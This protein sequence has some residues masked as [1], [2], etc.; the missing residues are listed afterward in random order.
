MD[1]RVVKFFSEN[2][3]CTVA[4]CQNGNPRASALEYVKVDDGII[5]ATDP[6]SIKAENLKAN[7]KLSISVHNMPV[8]V[9]VD[10]TTT[11]PSEAEINTYN[12]VLFERHPEFVEMMEKGMMRPFVYYKV[13]PETVYYNDYSK[14]MSPTEIISCK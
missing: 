13:V 7:N 9:T 6:S 10:G 2:V 14:G 8:F 3:V 4:T 12:T 1:S 11:T 5:F